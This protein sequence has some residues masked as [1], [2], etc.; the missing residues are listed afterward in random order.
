M[1]V[2]RAFIDANSCLHRQLDPQCPLT[3]FVR[4]LGQV[5]VLFLAAACADSHHCLQDPIQTPFA[6]RPSDFLCLPLSLPLSFCP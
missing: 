6:S 2:I 1:Y 4:V 5:T 3:V